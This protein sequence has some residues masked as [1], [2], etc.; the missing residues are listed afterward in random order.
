M[1]IRKALHR[2]E[3]WLQFIFLFFF[4]AFYSVA[5]AHFQAVA[6]QI[7]FSLP[8]LFLAFVYQVRIWSKYRASLKKSYHLPL[9]RYIDHSLC[10][11][12]K[13]LLLPLFIHFVVCLVTVPKPLPKRS[14]YI[15]RYTA[16]SLR[17]SSSFLRLLP[18]LPVTSIPP[19]IFPS[20][21]CRRR[22]FLRRMRPIQLAFRL[23]IS[24][25]I[26][27]YSSTLMNTWVIYDR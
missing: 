7:S 26:S 13:L 25:R 9:A 3:L 24:C 10:N 27:L 20:I 6:P 8:S 12:S 17:S 2:G 11:F 5:S 18:R 21:T 19:F 14:L 15:V 16:S 1:C 22:Q 23:L 4:F